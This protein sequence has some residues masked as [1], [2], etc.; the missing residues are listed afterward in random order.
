MCAVHR[1]AG[2]ATVVPL[3][4]PSNYA[5]QWVL[6]HLRELGEG[7]AELRLRGDQEPALQAVLH[8]VQKKRG[9]ATF[10]EEAPIASHASVGGVERYHRLLQEEVRALKLG[11]ER[12]LAGKV[13]VSSHPLAAWLV[14]HAS[15]ALFR[16]HV[17]REWQSTAYRRV[18]GSD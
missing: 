17:V 4:G 15:R 12:N 8:E 16:F 10:V 5:V 3:K 7:G 2:F 6:R 11:L 13:L 1:H 18:R 14:R 9:V